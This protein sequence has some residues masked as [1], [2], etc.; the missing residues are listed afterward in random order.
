MKLSGRYPLVAIVSLA[1]GSVSCIQ[2]C[3][4][5]K[6]GDHVPTG[7]IYSVPALPSSSD[8]VA[9]TEKEG[10]SR[11]AQKVVRVSDSYALCLHTD[12]FTD[13]EAKDL[14]EALK[15]KGENLNH[16]GLEFVLNHALAT[17]GRWFPGRGSFSSR[18]EFS[19]FREDGGNC[20]AIFLKAT[21]SEFPFNESPFQNR[22]WVLLASG[23]L[24][25][26]QTRV[27]TV[28]V[29]YLRRDAS[30]KSMQTIF[31]QAT[32]AFVGL[33]DSRM[34]ESLLNPELHPTEDLSFRIEKSN[35][36]TILD[37]DAAIVYQFAGVYQDVL[38]PKDLGGLQHFSD[39]IAPGMVST[40]PD[41]KLDG[42]TENLPF[43]DV[44]DS[45]YLR[46]VRT[47]PTEVRVC[48]QNVSDVV[49]NDAWRESYLEFADSSRELRKNGGL[50]FQ[51]HS[52]DESFYAK[53]VV[54]TDRCHVLV[55]FKNKTQYPFNSQPAVGLY[56]HEGSVKDASGNLTKIPVIYMNAS[57]IEPDPAAA[58]SL[59]RRVVSDVIQHEFAHFMGFQHSKSS[60]SILSAIGE[61]RTWDVS[62]DDT[63]M[64]KDYLRRRR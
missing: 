63:K 57:Q 17:I 21:S 40:D 60:S 22:H 64:F 23:Q 24:K 61:S 44:F 30:E 35:G 6:G 13:A 18:T 51:L 8:G 62:G 45:R 53:A 59:Q 20:H 34:D 47:I 19:I 46:G 42:S 2:S 54:V 10:G 48:M 36:Q 4:A 39:R 11:Y 38:N 3:T 29:I 1:F 31:V 28:P 9:L 7:E 58:I 41:L 33:G 56:A 52:L 26:R 12:G 15:T 43:L 16:S 32:A 25:D 55:L 27:N 14:D 49:I 5:D 50:F 37:D